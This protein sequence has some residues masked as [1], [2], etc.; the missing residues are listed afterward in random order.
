MTPI[1]KNSNT[2]LSATTENNT[3]VSPSPGVMG[4]F[5]NWCTGSRSITAVAK[6]TIQQ[7]QPE[8]PSNNESVPEQKTLQERQQSGSIKSVAPL[9]Q[10]LWDMGKYVAQQAKEGLVQV[11][12]A[13]QHVK[14]ELPKGLEVAK[15]RKVLQAAGLK[16]KAEHETELLQ[17]T[18][19]LQTLLL[20]IIR[21]KTGNHQKIHVPELLYTHTEPPT[22]IRNIEIE[23]TP[24]SQPQSLHD[25]SRILNIKSLSCDI[26]RPRSDGQPPQTMT[27][28]LQDALIK[29][30]S[31]IFAPAILLGKKTDFNTR[32]EIQAKKFALKCSHLPIAPYPFAPIDLPTGLT[33][34]LASLHTDNMELTDFHLNFTPEF[35]HRKKRVNNLLSFSSINFDNACDRPVFLDIKKMAW[36]NTK[37][38]EISDTQPSLAC[39]LSVHPKHLKQYKGLKWLPPS[40]NNFLQKIPEA[41]LNWQMDISVDASAPYGAIPVSS[42]ADTI[43]IRKPWLIKVVLRHLLK[44]AKTVRMSDS[45]C[46]IQLPVSFIPPIK[47]PG[48]YFQDNQENAGRIHLN[49]LM[50][51]I[52]GTK[53]VIISPTIHDTLAPAYIP[54]EQ[55]LSLA[56]D[57]FSQKRYHEALP[58]L[59]K[60]PISELSALSPQ[61]LQAHRPLLLWGLE[62]LTQLNHAKAL[63]LLKKLHHVTDDIPHPFATTQAGEI[64]RHAV[65]FEQRKKEARTPAEKLQCHKDYIAAIGPSFEALR[66]ICFAFPEGSP[67]ARHP[68]LQLADLAAQQQLPATMTV[69]LLKHLVSNECYNNHPFV[70]VQSLLLSQPIIKD[71]ACFLILRKL[72][73][74]II[75]CL[76][77][78]HQSGDDMAGHLLNKLADLLYQHNQGHKLISAFEHSP[79][80]LWQLMR[81]KIYSSNNVQQTLNMMSAINN[82]TFTDDDKSCD[83]AFSLLTEILI[84]QS[85]QTQHTGTSPHPEKKLTSKNREVL[86]SPAKNLI[87]TLF[88]RHFEQPDTLSR[89]LLQR[90][91]CAALNPL[92]TIDK[93]T[94]SDWTQLQQR[95]DEAY[96]NV[97]Q[98]R[99]LSKTS[100]KQ[101]HAILKQLQDEEKVFFQLKLV[102]YHATQINRMF[103]SSQSQNTDI[104]QIE[105]RIQSEEIL[106]IEHKSTLLSGLRLLYQQRNAR[107]TTDQTDNGIIS[108]LERSMLQ[109]LQ[110]THLIASSQNAER[111][112]QLR[113]SSAEECKRDEREPDTIIHSDDSDDED[114][115]YD[116]Y[117]EPF[118]NTG[119]NPVVAPEATGKMESEDD[120][121]DYDDFIDA[122]ETLSAKKHKD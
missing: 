114:R 28:A 67:P 50:S 101:L 29:M 48:L 87:T 65:V 8:S 113:T 16:I 40:L 66:A 59:D 44:N 74:H 46:G 20:D 68:L 97:T 55:Q 107:E 90:C 47:I 71:K 110:Q 116:T 76:S 108:F 72:N 26:I 115:F 70:L 31:D 3:T 60:M 88:Q 83:Q 112:Q 99:A 25:L 82:W 102:K 19:S 120:D 5:I 27:I 10:R 109:L 4:R 62:K 15:T 51:L 41:L 111:L 12:Q 94:R 100:R 49:E 56:D 119:T 7:A 45:S 54:I 73:P 24:D 92:L 30:E 33:P 14:N 35:A 93:D 89:G 38:L 98:D 79:A 106:T 103:A 78:A 39:E 34:S 86:T 53:M 1:D 80:R 58:F 23:V 6:T 69:P 21:N 104:N 42:L 2:P 13:I 22:V 85:D 18:S 32:I 96:N 91:Q 11:G 105:N 122:E 36:R 64:R 9:G 37:A 63:T 81:N 61:Q 118:P 75:T 57:L 77:N 95:F 52:S 117:E 43:K 84:P 17:A 121:D